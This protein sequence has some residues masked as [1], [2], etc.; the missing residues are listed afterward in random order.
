[1]S[2]TSTTTH[3]PPATPASHHEQPQ[4]SDWATSELGHHSYNGLAHPAVVPVQELLWSGRLT[5]DCTKDSTTF[6]RVPLPPEVKFIARL[7]AGHDHVLF[8]DEKG[9]LY[10]FG[11]TPSLFGVTGAASNKI[12][13]YPVTALSDHYIIDI[14]VGLY[15]S[16]AITDKGEA[17]VWGQPAAL[18]GLGVRSV[19]AMPTS[20]ATFSGFDNKYTLAAAGSTST[21]LLTQDGKVILLHQQTKSV[22]KCD[23]DITRSIR[24]V[25]YSRNIPLL[26][27]DDGEVF[28]FTNGKL[29]KYDSNQSEA[30]VHMSNSCLLLGLPRWSINTHQ[31]FPR[32]FKRAVK[33]ILVMSLVDE[34][35]PRYPEASWYKIPAEI[36]LIIIEFLGN[37][38]T[39]RGSGNVMIDEK[40][41]NFPERALD[42]AS[43]Y[44]HTALLTASGV[45]V[46]GSNQYGVGGDVTSGTQS[47]REFKQIPC[48]EGLNISRVFCGS[49]VTLAVVSPLG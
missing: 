15:H 13:V 37:S 9:K 4:Y 35:T 38:Y 44:A 47:V 43:G 36:T 14:A 45:W 49:Y 6:H 19:I 5:V 34:S 29:T 11:T 16:I 42:I 33:T 31:M 46:G 48:L 41:I 26:L 28:Q 3:T 20:L 22:Y 10:V 8:T 23:P 25:V 2:S 18:S 24:Q 40:I 12:V 39:K 27:S 17:F 21:I 32:E 7:C 1:M 30:V